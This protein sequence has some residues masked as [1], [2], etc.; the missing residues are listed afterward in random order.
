MMGYQTTGNIHDFNKI[1]LIALR[2]RAR[3]LPGQLPA[4]RKE[5]SSPIPAVEIVAEFAKAGFEE[6][7][8]RGFPLQDSLGLVLQSR[9]DQRRFEDR[10]VRVQRHQSIEVAAA[11]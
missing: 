3:I 4:V 6:G 8:D 2:R 5:R 11:D 10:V 7:P 1:D 9:E